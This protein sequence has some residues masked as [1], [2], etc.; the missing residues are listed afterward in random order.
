MNF[1]VPDVLEKD[2]WWIHGSA[3]VGKSYACRK[4]FPGIYCKTQNKWWDGYNGEDAV[5][6][7]DFDKHGACLAHYLKIWADGYAFN[8]EIKGGMVRPRYHTLLVTSNYLPE[9]IFLDDAELLAAIKRRFKVIT[10][11]NRAGQD[12][13]IQ[14]I[15][16]KNN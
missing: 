9:D 3:G 2:C 11:E 14:K 6:L 5:L 8:A 7:D 10:L 13:L 4:A 15:Q 16:Q 12:A 1:T